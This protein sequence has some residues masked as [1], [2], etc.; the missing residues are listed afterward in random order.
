M[1][2]IVGLLLAAGLAAAIAPAASPAATTKVCPIPPVARY[3]YPG[4]NG[5]WTLFRAKGVTCATSYRVAT[6]FQKCRLKNGV[7]GRC[8]KKVADGWAC[9]EQRNSGP[10]SFGAAVT[11]SKGRATVGHNYMQTTSG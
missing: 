4:T 2:T 8:V 6:A 9:R 1:R 3:P 10:T 11:C 7:S 5:T